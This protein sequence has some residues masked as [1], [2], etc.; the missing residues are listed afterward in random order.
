MYIIMP[1]KGE[2][3]RLGDDRVEV[4]VREA[5]GLDTLEEPEPRSGVCY[6]R[7]LLLAGSLQPART[8]GKEATD[9][10]KAIDD[11]RT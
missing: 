9:A 11:D 8:S 6:V 2:E 1:K 10:A 3:W 7:G 5:V 4:G